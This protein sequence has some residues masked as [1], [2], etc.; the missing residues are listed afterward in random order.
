VRPDLF[1]IRW[2]KLHV[3]LEYK[4]GH[5]VTIYPGYIQYKPSNKLTIDISNSDTDWPLL[6]NEP[7]LKIILEVICK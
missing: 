4:G 3:D 6:K 2:D 7:G 1:D 5:I